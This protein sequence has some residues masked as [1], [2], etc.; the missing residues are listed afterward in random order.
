MTSAREVENKTYIK[1]IKALQMLFAKE[2]R[3]GGWL[4]GGREMAKRMGI[5]HSTYCKAIERLER[6]CFV[7]SYPC[8]GHYVVPNNN[9]CHKIGIIIEDGIES[10]FLEEGDSFIA[11]LTALRMGGFDIQFL[12]ATR[13]EQLHDSAIAHGVDGVIWFKPSAAVAPDTRWI[14]ES[15]EMPL[16]IV[17]WG[18]DEDTDFGACS[19]S[20]DYQALAEAQLQAMHQRHHSRLAVI[21]YSYEKWTRAII[22]LASK[23]KIELKLLDLTQKPDSKMLE[24]ILL[25]FHP[26]GIISCGGANTLTLVAETLSCISPKLRPEL[27]LSEAE[28]AKRLIVAKKKIDFMMIEEECPLGEAAAQLMIAHIFQGQPL[29]NRKINPS[30]AGLKFFSN[31]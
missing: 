13:P 29:F 30:P 18:Q 15:G 22:A 2:Y 24:E 11:C 4:P 21:G 12:H 1:A 20:K 8:K 6:E 7:I 3:E 31:N 17:N 9:R 27:L 23:K 10:P 5:G 26:T 19:V 16:I 28:P 14:V 25:E